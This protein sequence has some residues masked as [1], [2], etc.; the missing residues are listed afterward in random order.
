MK[1][2]NHRAGSSLKKSRVLSPQDHV[3]FGGRSRQYI[4]HEMSHD[5]PVTKRSKEFIWTRHFS[6]V[7][8]STSCEHQRRK[9]EKK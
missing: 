9:I 5:I 4:A 3:R 7:Q 2:I 8:R 1:L 6:Q